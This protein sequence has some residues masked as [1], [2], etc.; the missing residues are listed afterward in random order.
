MRNLAA[1]YP[2]RGIAVSGHGSKEDID[3]SIAAGFSHHITKPVN[4][5]EL[6]R[7]IQEI[8]EESLRSKNQ[9]DPPAKS[10]QEAPSTTAAAPS[11]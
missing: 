9:V 5:N 6:Q 10:D 2:I 8:A 7:A 4:W 1:R 11:S 3:S